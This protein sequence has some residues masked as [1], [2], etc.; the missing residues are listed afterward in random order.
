MVSEAYWKVGQG[1][2][3]RTPVVKEVHFSKAGNVK[4]NHAVPGGRHSQIVNRIELLSLPNSEP[5]WFRAYWSENGVTFSRV[6]VA[7]G[8]WCV[9]FK[10]ERH[11]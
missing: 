4:L 3:T 8:E 5:M 7:R 11:G 1:E 9:V 10:E 2:A 6:Y